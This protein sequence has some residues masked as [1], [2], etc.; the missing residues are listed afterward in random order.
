MTIELINVCLDDFVLSVRDDL[1]ETLKLYITQTCHNVFVSISARL[2]LTALLICRG[3]YSHVELQ[4]CYPRQLARAKVC[5]NSRIYLFA[6]VTLSIKQIELNFLNLVYFELGFPKEIHFLWD[7]PRGGRRVVYSHSNHIYIFIIITYLTNLYTFLI[8]SKL[9]YGGGDII[10]LPTS[11]IKNY[12][13]KYIKRI[14]LI[15]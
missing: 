1:A 13:Y 2:L 4:R 14:L 10:K 9:Y 7:Y 12:L 8:T 6:T 3:L 5:T 11:I 15:Y